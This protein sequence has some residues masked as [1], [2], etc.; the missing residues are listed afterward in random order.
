MD[1]D[2]SVV[3]LSAA[4]PGMTMPPNEPIG[5]MAQGEEFLVIQSGDLVTLPLF[6]D[7]AILRRSRGFLGIGAELGTPDNSFTITI[8]NENDTRVGTV[9]PPEAC[10]QQAVE[11]SHSNL[12]LPF[13]PL[14]HLRWP[15]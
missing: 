10:S 2:N 1:T 9:I 12:R 3:D 8:R 6:W 7:G 4:F 13:Q 11:T 14:A 15:I 5:F